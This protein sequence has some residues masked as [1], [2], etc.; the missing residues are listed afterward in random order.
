MWLI[1]SKQLENQL[2]DNKLEIAQWKEIKL[3]KFLILLKNFN[4]I[5]NNQL[6]WA[7]VK[8]ELKHRSY[9]EKKL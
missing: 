8:K 6:T 3:T 9:W 7:L 4:S 1:K 2:E 5:E